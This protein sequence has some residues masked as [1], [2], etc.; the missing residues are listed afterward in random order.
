MPVGWCEL[1]RSHKRFVSGVQV[2]MRSDSFIGGKIKLCGRLCFSSQRSTSLTALK[3]RKM[4]FQRVFLALI[5]EIQQCGPC[6][7]MQAS[8]SLVVDKHTRTQ[9]AAPMCA[10]ELG[11]T[12]NTTSVDASECLQTLFSLHPVSLSNQWYK[13][14]AVKLIL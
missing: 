14:L 2:D 13:S 3:R 10:Y 12:K 4:L 1:S 8:L 5:N 9:L 6:T 7:S 11:H